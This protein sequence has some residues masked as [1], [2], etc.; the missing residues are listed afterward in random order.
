MNR[1][2]FLHQTT[3]ASLAT[4]LPQVGHTKMVEKMGIVVHSYWLRW[5][6]KIESS[7]FPPLRNALDLLNHCHQLGAGGIQVGIDH[8]TADFAKQVRNI[9]ENWGLYVEG[10]VSL[11]KT[12][13]DTAAFEQNIIQ[14][15]DA[16]VKVV[17]TVCSAGRRYEAYHSLADFRAFE[18]NAVAVLEAIEPILRKHRVALGVEN[19]KD[20]RADEMAAL[21][22]KLS[23]E[24][25]GA[26]ID[27]GNNWALLEDPT[28]TVHTLAPF[29]KSTHLKDM[30]VEAYTDGFRLSEV[31]LGEGI[32]DLPALVAVCRQYNPAVTFSLEMI[33]REPLLIP[34]LT[35]AYWETFPNLPG[36]YLAHT[37][38]T[39]NTRSNKGGLPTI[40]HLS[41]EEKL[42]AE[43]ANIRLCLAYGREKLGL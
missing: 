39:V 36:R 32:L 12:P 5:Q 43:D 30:A 13:N 9:S 22:K 26:T 16:G 19:H 41:P 7:R 24:W 17:R 14:A 34:C 1:R 18:Q 35:E 2:D 23:S 6:S 10:S 3:T 11:P 38:K 25:I 42:A 21:L 40:A 20:W 28:E 8:W 15:K 31:P 27:F 33:T 29:V 37:L 4:L